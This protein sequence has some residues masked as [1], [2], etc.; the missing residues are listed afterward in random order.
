MTPSSTGAGFFDQ[1][2]A[3][4]VGQVDREIAKG[5]RSSAFNAR[6]K[7]ALACRILAEEGHAR[8]L[9]G[10]ITVRAGQATSFWTTPFGIGFAETN[11]SH[12]LCT[13]AEMR[14]VE[15]EGMANPAV[16]FHLWVYRARP[17][18]N[19]IVHT[20]PRYS[21][22]LSMVGR[23]LGVAHMDATMFHNDCAWLERWPGVPLANEEGRLISEALGTKRTILLAHHGLLTTGKTLEEA[24][25]LAVLFEQAAQLQ[26]LAESIGTIRAVAPDLAQEAHDFLLKDSVVNA[27]F[28]YWARQIAR[29]YPETLRPSQQSTG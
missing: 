9:A 1:S 24:L 2:A 23:P 8:T 18:I 20:H 12:L 25:Y 27:T 11:V 10:Q 15:G 29:K 26:V 21:A 13:D 28:E 19:C 5:L 22:A 4:I 17:D 14:T 3:D 16:R 6:E 7:L